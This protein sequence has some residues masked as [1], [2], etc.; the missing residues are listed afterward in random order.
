MS[1]SS[2]ERHSPATTAGGLIDDRPS[3]PLAARP[4]RSVGIRLSFALAIPGRSLCSACTNQ[5]EEAGRTRRG[6]EEDDRASER[7]PGC[8]AC[9]RR[10]CTGGRGSHACLRS[11]VS[12]V[13]RCS[14]NS[15][16]RLDSQ[17]R[18][19]GKRPP[20]PMTPAPPM[21]QKGDTHEHRLTLSTSADPGVTPWTRFRCWI[22]CEGIYPLAFL[23]TP[24]AKPCPRCNRVR[25]WT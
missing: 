8:H 3:L 1:R 14:E 16:A 7:D 23:G 11:I 2:S 4:G 17:D 21:I 6:G 10:I 19:C 9:D 13:R 18:G 20:A 24:F 22:S 5:R 25:F 12:E 15:R